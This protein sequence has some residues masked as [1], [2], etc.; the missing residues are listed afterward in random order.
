M[1]VVLVYGRVSAEDQAV[2]GHS[3]AAQIEDCTGRA[4]SLG[5]REQDVLLFKDEGY[6]GDEP[7]RPGLLELRE[8]VR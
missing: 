6:S 3:I 4:L 5:Y 2:R 1:A 8:A 7:E